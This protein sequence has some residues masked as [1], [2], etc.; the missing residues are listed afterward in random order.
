MPQHKSAVKRVKTNEKRR[1][2]NRTKKVKMRRALKA[3]RTAQTKEELIETSR[4]AQQILDRLS[5]KGIVHKN[6][7]SNRKRQFARMIA[8][9]DSAS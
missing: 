9:F 3:V 6:Y 5:T 7:A 8:R 2:E 4:L 1:L